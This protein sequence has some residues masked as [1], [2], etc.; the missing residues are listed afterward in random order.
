VR[1]RLA[2]DGVGGVGVARVA[3]GAARVRAVTGRVPRAANG[4]VA[5]RAS[6]VVVV[7][8]GASGARVGESGAVRVASV[9]VTSNVVLVASGG[10]RVV[11]AVPA[12]GVPASGEAGPVASGEAAQGA[13]G[14]DVRMS[15]VV[16]ANAPEAAVSVAEAVKVPGEVRVPGA[17]RVP[18]DV[19]VPG[20]ATV[21]EMARTA[22]HAALRPGRR[23]PFGWRSAGGESS[24]TATRASW[25]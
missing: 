5:R 24:C 10:A 9:P 23:T 17:V 14:G 4:G 11:S 22:P 3:A 8:E 13:T 18:G 7:P 1:G 19:R 6:E 15:A 21:G 16:A 20:V 25:S 2:D 12:S